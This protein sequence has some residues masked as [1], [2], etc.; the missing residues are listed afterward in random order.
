MFDGLLYIMDSW[1]IIVKEEILGAGEIFS[2]IAFGRHWIG[3]STQVNDMCFSYISNFE[4]ATL[5]QG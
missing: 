2:S 1:I 4:I 3:S 5:G